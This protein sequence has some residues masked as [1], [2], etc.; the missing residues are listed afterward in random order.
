MAITPFEPRSGPP[1]TLR[2]G[3]FVGHRTRSPSLSMPSTWLC[4][5]RPGSAMRRAQPTSGLSVTRARPC[6]SRS[7]KSPPQRAKARRPPPR[8]SGAEAQASRTALPVKDRFV[9]R[10]SSSTTRRRHEIR[11]RTNQRLPCGRGISARGHVS[12]A[13]TSAARSSCVSESRCAY[14]RAVMFGSACPR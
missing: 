13:K 2:C 6:A 9:S 3:R 12:R 7:T 14:T 4:G 8:A 1:R 5:R 10:R 11:R